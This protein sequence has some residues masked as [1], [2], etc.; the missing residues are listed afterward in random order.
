VV[1]FNR[2][3]TRA[4]ASSPIVTPATPSGTTH[5]GAPGYARDAKS[6]L[7][8]LAVA[9]MV[10]ED[11]FYEG[12]GDRDDRYRRLVR[13]V[14]VRDGAWMLG[15]LTWLRGEAAMRSASLVGAA[16]AVKA[17][18]D[19]ARAGAGAA[20][21]SDGSRNRQLV[22]AVLRRADEPGELLAYWT[23][24]HGRAIPKP[25][26]R[27]VGDAVGRLYT[28]YNL[29][30][31]DTDGHAFRFGDVLELAHPSPAAPWQGSLFRHALDR[32]HGRGDGVP[33]GLAMVAANA[34][35]RAAAGSAPDVL[36][37]SGRLRDAGMTWEDAL[38]LGGSRVDRRALWEALIPSM[39]YMALLRNLRNFDEAGVSDGVA[40][41]VAARLADPEQV[42][43]S[44]QLPMRYLSAHRAAPSLRWSYPLERALA[45]STANIPALRGRTLVLVDT[46]GSMN[47]RFARDG[48]LLRWD[49]AVLFGVAL[50]QRSD[51]ADV[52]S[53]STGTRVFRLKRGESLLRALE[54]W[55][56]G[57][58][59]LNG[60]TD[61][62]LAVR[63]HYARHD[64]VVIVT[65]EQAAY[66]G[67][68]D[69][70]APVPPAVPV[71]TWNLAGYRHGHAPSGTGNRHTFGGLGD[72]AFRMIPLI[73]A[74]R[75]AGWPWA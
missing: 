75:N 72:Q 24:R 14:A 68:A 69:V 8:L 27:G 73:E 2:T 45:A 47:S 7:F 28:E 29:L 20:P 30:K 50:A 51:R 46:S 39:G 21:Q 34:A 33:A 25:V 74:G 62:A 41:T 15:F 23:A 37:D 42:A 36:L 35:L 60:G 13:E 70:A 22:D 43:R 17:R 54:R 53:F 48:T 32:R 12:G 63:A 18:L 66:S 65:D 1:K 55:R 44:R 57:G 59:F 71:Y 61:T 16:E 64:R 5:E 67:Y 11:T 19:A 40:A 58:W 38:S 52:V 3:R 31:Y 26:K 56:K 10:G 9:N 4:G 6:E 49:A